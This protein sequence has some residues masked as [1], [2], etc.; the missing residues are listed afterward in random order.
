MKTYTKM[1]ST[2]QGNLSRRSWAIAKEDAFKLFYRSKGRVS[3][4]KESKATLKTLHKQQAHEKRM[5]K[6]LQSL[7][8]Y[9]D[10]FEN[11]A[12]ALFASGEF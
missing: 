9:E 12:A 8:S 7:A 6:V 5:L 11:N 2:L 4:V 1:I 10:A 3:E